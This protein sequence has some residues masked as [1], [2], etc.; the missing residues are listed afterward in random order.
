MHKKSEPK[1]DLDCYFGIEL[2][3]SDGDNEDHDTFEEQVGCQNGCAA[4]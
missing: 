4:I 3:D 2:D 1:A